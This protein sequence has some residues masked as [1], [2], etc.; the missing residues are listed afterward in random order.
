VPTFAGNGS[1]AAARSRALDCQPDVT[2][3]AASVGIADLRDESA[4][5]LVLESFAPDSPT[6]IWAVA[7]LTMTEDDCVDDFV[8]GWLDGEGPIGRGLSAA[9]GLKGSVEGRSL[10]LVGCDKVRRLTVRS[11]AGSPPS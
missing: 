10:G 2:V 6:R 9:A 7:G 1:L 4:V 5:A 3:G 11:R 8:D